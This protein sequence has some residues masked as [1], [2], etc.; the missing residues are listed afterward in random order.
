MEK[1]IRTIRVSYETWKAIKILTTE[2]E[3]TADQ[4]IQE[5]LKSLPPQD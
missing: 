2:R 3:I 5:M 1:Q 4:L